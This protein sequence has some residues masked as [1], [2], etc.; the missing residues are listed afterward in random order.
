MLKASRVLGAI[1]VVLFAAVLAS[2]A[3]ASR[4]SAGTMAAINGPYIAGTVISAATVNARLAD[5]E[6]EITDSL[7]RS[8]KGG[9]LFALRGVDGS[10]AA[11]ALSFTSD[12]DTGLYRIGANDL[13]LS[14]G[15][16]LLKEWTTG[17]VMTIAGSANTVPVQWYQASLADAGTVAVQIGKANAAGQA[18]I[19]TYTKNATAANSTWC[20]G[21]LSG[22]AS[23]LCVDGNN[24]TIIGASGTA[25]G[26]YRMTGGTGGCATAASIGATCD[27]TVT[28]PVAF[29]DAS[30][31]AWCT[32]T[33]TVTSG[34]PV[35][36]ILN[37]YAAATVKVRT[38]ALTA[39]AAQFGGI[40]CFAYHQ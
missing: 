8:G 28:W 20:L 34:V 2:S 19:L 13:G 33:G 1:A 25:I 11:P 40:D 5:I 29:A 18:G 10:A 21:V 32:A 16:V 14:V 23:T 7:D 39:A 26:G 12:T 17:E 36:Q 24:K 3:L 31:N 37:S 35:I 15:G 4:N 27:T 9:M 38:V 30:Y 22:S 6:T